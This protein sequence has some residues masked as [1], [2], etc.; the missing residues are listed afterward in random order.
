MPSTIP[1]IHQELG[2]LRQA[3]RLRDIQ[4]QSALEASEEASRRPT[5]ARGVAAVMAS[6]VAALLP[7]RG[8]TQDT[9][10]SW[11]R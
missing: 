4:F 1:T 9:M 10:G 7:L 2:R 3:D 6:A 8:A 5:N 11:Q